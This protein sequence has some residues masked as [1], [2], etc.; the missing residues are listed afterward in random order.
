MG[1][2]SDSDLAKTIVSV[3]KANRTR[4]WIDFTLTTGSRK[5]QI[6]EQHRFIYAAPRDSF[7]I[8]T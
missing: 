7:S 8:I 5:I 4:A 1:L 3:W 6:T 2:Y